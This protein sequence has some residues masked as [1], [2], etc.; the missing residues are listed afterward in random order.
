MSTR[1]HTIPGT[2]ENLSLVHDATPFNPGR[3]SAPHA[4]LVDGIRGVASIGS[5]GAYSTRIIIT[6]EEDHPEL[7]REFGTK[8]FLIDEP[9]VVTWG[10]EGKSF[11]IEKIID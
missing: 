7:G 11:N 3:V 4:V 9:G 8:Y 2:E 5:H 1:L 10:H 6:L